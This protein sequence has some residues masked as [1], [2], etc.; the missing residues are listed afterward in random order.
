[1]LRRRSL[2]GRPGFDAQSL[3]SSDLPDLDNGWTTFAHG[4][5][6][7]FVLIRSF[8]IGRPLVSFWSGSVYVLTIWDNKPIHGSGTE[9]NMTPVV[10]WLVQARK[11]ITREWSQDGRSFY[12]LSLNG[13]SLYGRSLCGLSLYGLS[14]CGLSLYGLSLN[15]F[16]GYH[17]AGYRFT[18]YRFTGHRLAAYRFTAYRFAGYRFTGYRFT[19]DRFTV[20]IR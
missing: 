5:W 13:L 1:M 4:W 14:L 18:S 10:L 3:F 11:A 19:G 16:R 9:A 6:V 8:M 12:G 7:L 2:A 17:S 20:P 15:G